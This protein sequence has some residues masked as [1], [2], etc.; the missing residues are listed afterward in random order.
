MPMKFLPIMCKHFYGL[1]SDIIANDLRST[2]HKEQ[3]GRSDTR[4]T[5]Y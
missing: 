5:K 3:L 2:C 1:V 4:G